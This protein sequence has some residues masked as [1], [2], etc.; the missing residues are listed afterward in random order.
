MSRRILWLNH[1]RQW[2]EKLYHFYQSFH[3]VSI[4]IIPINYKKYEIL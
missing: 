1:Y 4:I 2:Q 3:F